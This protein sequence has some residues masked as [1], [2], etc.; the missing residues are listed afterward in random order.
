VS[1]QPDPFHDLKGLIRTNFFREFTIPYGLHSSFLAPTVWKD[2]CGSWSDSFE[3]LDP[4]PGVKIALEFEEKV[5]EKIIK[6][7]HF[8]IFEYFAHEKK[9][10]FHG[11][12][13]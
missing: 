1:R 12:F 10:Y 13:P 6:K 7:D 4:D 8:H 5:S 11:L 9:E 3:L 2:G